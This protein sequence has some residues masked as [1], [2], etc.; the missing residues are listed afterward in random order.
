MP[1]KKIVVP[2]LF[3]ILI[4]SLLFVLTSFIGNWS[5]LIG[6]YFVLFLIGLPALVAFSTSSGFVYGAVLCGYFIFLS[7]LFYFASEKNRRI[8]LGLV[9]LV[10]LLSVIFAVNQVY[11]H[12][13]FL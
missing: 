5:F 13:H 9:I 3:G 10:H 8:L 1:T 7:I 11:R 6:Y 4:A 2:V 12:F